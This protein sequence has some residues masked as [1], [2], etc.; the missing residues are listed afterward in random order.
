[1]TVGP[2][3]VDR[4]ADV[5][6]IGR[7]MLPEDAAP[8]ERKYGYKPFAVR[9]GGG[10]FDHDQKIK[11]TAIIVNPANPIDKLSLDELDAIFSKTRKRGYKEDIRTWGQLG[12][13]GDWANRA[14]TLYGIKSPGGIAFIGGNTA[15]LQERVLRGG[16]YKDGVKRFENIGSLRS[17]AREAE[18]VAQDPAAIG[19]VGFG[20]TKGVKALALAE[21]KGGPYYRG[22]F[23]DVLNQRYPLS[24]V[25]YIFLNRPPGKPIDPAIKEFLLFILS[26][27][28]QQTLLREGDF[29]PLPAEIVKEERAKLE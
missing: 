14:I 22:T 9:V 27:Q 2:A 15:F 10:T 29:L 13:K 8:F 3:L 11:P 5:G 12:L 26:R 18:A 16:E 1:M 28:G 21:R 4:T 6:V 17:F 25:I 24:R 19:A 23:E 20:Y 7:D